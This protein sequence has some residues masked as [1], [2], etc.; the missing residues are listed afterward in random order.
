MLIQ[1]RL[2]AALVVKNPATSAGDI[3]EEDSIPGSER[4]PG[5]GHVNPLLYDCLENPTGRRAWGATDHRVAV[6]DMTKRVSK[7]R[8]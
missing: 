2:Q 8:T 3:R 1:W 7:D 6:S 4:S 5:G